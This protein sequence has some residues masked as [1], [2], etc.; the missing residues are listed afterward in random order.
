MYR[1]KAA[2]NGMAFEAPLDISD[3]KWLTRVEKSIPKGLEEGIPEKY[4]PDYD[5]LA[6][7]RYHL[8]SG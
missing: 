6:I 1:N 3:G 4:D 8:V 5:S 2:V 7:I